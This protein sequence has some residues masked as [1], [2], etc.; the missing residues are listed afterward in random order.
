[1][2]RNDP[3]NSLYE[4][5]K[6]AI[7]ERSKVRYKCPKCGDKPWGK[8][9]FTRYVYK[10]THKYIADDVGRCDHEKCGYHLPP[11]EYFKRGGK[12][13][14]PLTE[15]QLRQA[16]EQWRRE[17]ERERKKWAYPDTIDAA[18]IQRLQPRLEQS[19]LFQWLVSKFG[20]ERV[21]AACAAYYVGG[22]KDGRSVFP[23]IDRAGRCR[24]AKVMRYGTDGHRAKEGINMVRWVPEMLLKFARK[25]RP[26]LLRYLHMKDQE[27]FDPAQCWFGSHLITDGATVVNVVESEKTAI[28][29]RILQPQQIWLATGGDLYMQPKFAPDL[30]G[31]HVNVFPDV[32]KFEMW[33]RQM[34]CI[35]C[36]SYEVKTW[37]TLEGVQDKMD[38]LDFFTDILP[39]Y[40]P[41]QVA[42]VI[43]ILSAAQTAAK[44]TPAEEVSKGESKGLAQPEQPTAAP[45]Q[46]T[47]PTVEVAAA[48]KLTERDRQIRDA[49]FTTPA[50]RYLFNHF[51]CEVVDVTP[52]G[53]PFPPTMSDAEYSRRLAAGLAF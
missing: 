13:P 20:V 35:K 15:E 43:A 40:T 49:F 32:G 52:S 47:A 21:T 19:T 53:Y 37:H 51:Q 26:D 7:G 45:E 1:M 16:A 12:V 41:E 14:P 18:L 3:Y 28:G 36:K 24:T 17:E 29:C 27:K 9:S 50:L 39:T 34:K 46:P 4:L 5:E 23:Q 42:R 2:S 25:E 22:T 6:Y 8:H 30:S 31:I 38:I 33:S 10:G 11:W 48:P 44:Q